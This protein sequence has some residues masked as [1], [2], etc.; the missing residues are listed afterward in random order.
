[1]KSNSVIYISSRVTYSLELVTFGGRNRYHLV[2]WIRRGG[3]DSWI[4]WH[5]PVTLCGMREPWEPVHLE[6]PV[7]SCHACLDRV[8]LAFEDV[9]PELGIPAR[10]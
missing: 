7:Q 6:R 1:M 4:D 9:P 2:A 5:A 8:E 10:G 3:K